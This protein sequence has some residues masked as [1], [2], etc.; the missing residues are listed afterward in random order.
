MEEAQ[1]Q[2]REDLVKGYHAM[3]TIIHENENENETQKQQ[4]SASALKNATRET[5]IK[6]ERVLHL[7]LELLALERAMHE[8]G[9][10]LDNET[11]ALEREAAVHGEDVAERS[12]GRVGGREKD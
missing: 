11:I 1:T 5:K 3:E 12:G 8:L 4:H 9:V 2:K 6:E 7:P 10:V